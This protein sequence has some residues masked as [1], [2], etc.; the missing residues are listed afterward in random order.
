MF[1]FENERGDPVDNLEGLTLIKLNLAERI[2][3]ENSIEH[4]HEN[5]D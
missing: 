1:F 5:G 3:E 2:K 4:E